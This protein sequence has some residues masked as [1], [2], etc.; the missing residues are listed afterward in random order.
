[1]SEEN[2]NE[3]LE[4]KEAFSAEELEEQAEEGKEEKPVWEKRGFTSL[5]AMVAHM[6]GDAASSKLLQ[7]RAEEVLDKQ[8]V[9]TP[10]RLDQDRL[11][12]EGES[13]LQEYHQKT[14]DFYAKQGKPQ[15]HAALLDAATEGVLTTAEMLEMDKHVV[16]GMMRSIAMESPAKQEMAKTVEGIRLIGKEALDKL[17]GTMG[18][19]KAATPASHKT[20]KGGSPSGPA[21]TKSKKSEVETIEDEIKTAGQSGDVDSV[22]DLVLKKQAAKLKKKGD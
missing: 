17:E 6:D 18:K 2:L 9:G 22:I 1:M 14:G 13:Y 7:Q 12:A 21:P 4:N 8:V 15:T 16:Y 3:E 10:P 20:P 11:E 19:K 5:E